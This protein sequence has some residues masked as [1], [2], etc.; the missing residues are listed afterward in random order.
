MTET[1]TVTREQLLRI[2]LA[3]AQ[4]GVAAQA[5]TSLHPATPLKQKLCIA[6]EYAQRII[7]NWA[8][9]PMHRLEADSV[10]D[11]VLGVES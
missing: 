4:V 3:G 5:A 8:D 11:L 1:L 6:G 2:Y 10:I 7:T 9:D